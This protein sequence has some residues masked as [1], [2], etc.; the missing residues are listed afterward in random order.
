MQIF[1]NRTPLN[2]VHV[3]PVAE[4]TTVTLT[5]IPTTI[6]GFFFGGPKL[7][8]LLGELT[9]KY[10]KL[11]S[12]NLS[13]RDTINFGYYFNQNFILPFK[14]QK[15]KIYEKNGRPCP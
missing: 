1:A 5:E 4:E 13:L 14:P 11:W 7:Y 9:T 2:T 10:Q 15:F 3:I 12:V 6:D 8:S